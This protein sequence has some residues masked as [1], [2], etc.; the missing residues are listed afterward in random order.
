MDLVLGM[1]I[2][3]LLYTCYNLLKLLQIDPSILIPESSVTIVLLGS[4][5]RFMVGSAS[6]WNSCAPLHPEQVSEG[7]KFL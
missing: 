7:I 6:Y 5:N 4:P 1:E 3:A 2:R